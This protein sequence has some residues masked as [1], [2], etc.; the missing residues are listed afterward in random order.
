MQAVKHSTAERI[1]GRAVILLLPVQIPL[2]AVHTVLG[3]DTLAPLPMYEY[4][5]MVV[6][7][8]EAVQNGSHVFVVACLEKH[9]IKLRL[10]VVLK[11]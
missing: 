2:E 6:V 8:V 5:C 7:V 11:G 4:G 3:Q 9:Y 1:S 10:Y